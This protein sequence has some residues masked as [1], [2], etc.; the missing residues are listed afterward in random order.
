MP[1]LSSVHTSR[2]LVAGMLYSLAVPY[3]S[4]MPL[5]WAA[6][7]DTKAPQ[8]GE[9]PLAGSGKKLFESLCIACH[10]VDGTGNGPV[11]QAL[12]PKPPDLT[13]ITRRRGGSADWGEISKFIDG[14]TEVA[15]HG[16]RQMPVWGKELQP[17]A[18]DTSVKEEAVQGDLAAIVEYLRSIQA[19]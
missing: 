19:K 18:A 14:R 2:L 11:A 7:S 10:G 9:Q 8:G 4:P 12:S 17:H 13:L 1:M 6:P 5:A 16:S 3:L 15:A